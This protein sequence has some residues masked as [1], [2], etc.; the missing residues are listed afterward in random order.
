[1]DVQVAELPGSPCA[2]QA[3][4]TPAALEFC[5]REG[6]GQELETALAL[7]ERHFACSASQVDLAR[8]PDSDEEWLAARVLFHGSPD[9]FRARRRQFARDWIAR[10]H[11]AARYKVRLSYGII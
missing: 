2:T 4:V 3:E 7:A 11:P 5:R 6:I 10:T 1:M 8:D 9:E